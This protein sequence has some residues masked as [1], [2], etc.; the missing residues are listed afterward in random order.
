MVRIVNK[1]S[2]MVGRTKVIA[3][4]SWYSDV[5]PAF[6][7]VECW[8][9]TLEL[10]NFCRYMRVVFV[11]VGG[12]CSH[13]R[14]PGEYSSQNSLLLSS[15]AAESETAVHVCEGAREEGEVKHVGK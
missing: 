9:R 13:A 10:Q 8:G 12:Q 11:Y 7:F 14:N 5:Y 1:Y 3:Q 4:I 15:G 6:L 2:A